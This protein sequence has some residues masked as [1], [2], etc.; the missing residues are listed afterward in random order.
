MVFIYR[1]TSVLWW[2]ALLARCNPDALSPQLMAYKMINRRS[3]ADIDADEYTYRQEA[4][5][6]KDI[7]T[8][9]PSG[10]KLLDTGVTPNPSFT[11][12]VVGS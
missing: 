12:Q 4:A 7:S 8:I 5:S 10:I 6:D 1:M 3:K 9:L 2:P 11:Q